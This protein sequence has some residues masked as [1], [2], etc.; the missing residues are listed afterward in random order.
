MEKNDYRL[1]LIRHAYGLRAGLVCLISLGILYF[2]GWPVFVH[3]KGIQNQ[4]ETKTKEESDLTNKI[5]LLSGLDQEI[6]RE[7]MVLINKALPPNKD[8]VLYLSTIDG[9][10]KELGLV[11]NSIKI[12]P[13]DVTTIPEGDSVTKTK[14]RL[15]PA[16]LSSLET[17]IKVSGSKDNIYSFLRM[18][19]E[20]L[21]LMQIKDIKISVLGEN[22]FSL[23]LQLGM[24]WASFD[25][26]T[27]NGTITLFDQQEEGYFQ[28][29]T[30]YPQ[31]TNDLG[32]D[33]STGELGKTNIFEGVIPQQ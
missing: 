18:V 16:G 30:T 5:S 8:V 12:M 23:S 33:A 3:M 32:I 7:R 2:V 19:E 10:S 4:I 22:Q 21:P 26:K 27:V 20:S 9:L 15:V 17:T 28:R 6:L 13:G 31:Y 11:F 24:L 1:W 25:P 29:L 14:K